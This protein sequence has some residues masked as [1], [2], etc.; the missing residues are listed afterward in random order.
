MT[1]RKNFCAQSPFKIALIDL[2]FSETK[3]IFDTKFEKF[4]LEVFTTVARLRC[5]TFIEKITS[6]GR[7]GATF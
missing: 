3:V 5:A 2:H 1:I 4:V 6:S 7:Y